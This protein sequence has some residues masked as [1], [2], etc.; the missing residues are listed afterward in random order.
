MLRKSIMHEISLARNI[1]EL[2]FSFFQ[3][4]TIQCHKADRPALR[5]QP[6]VGRGEEPPPQKFF[7][8]TLNKKFILEDLKSS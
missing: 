8:T 2:A 7:E 5:V 3:R 1:H 6:S 4:T